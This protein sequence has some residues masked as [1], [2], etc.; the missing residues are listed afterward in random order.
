[1]TG[2]LPSIMVLIRT[3]CN[4]SCDGRFRIADITGESLPILEGVDF[5][6][7]ITHAFYRTFRNG[8]HVLGRY[9]SLQKRFAHF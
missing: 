5:A 2:D 7:S 8:V 4:C 6:Y 9:Q 3:W 1:M